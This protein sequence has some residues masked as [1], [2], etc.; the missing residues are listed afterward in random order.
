M[1]IES[2]DIVL[3]NIPQGGMAHPQKHC[4]TEVTQEKLKQASNTLHHPQ[5]TIIS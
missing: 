5:I 2:I 4:N 3:I 1:F